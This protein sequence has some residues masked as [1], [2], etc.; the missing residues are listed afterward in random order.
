MKKQN[1]LSLL[2]L[3]ASIVGL[4]A[5]DQTGS[6]EPSNNMDAYKLIYNGTSTEKH[7]EIRDEDEF[8][9]SSYGYR[10][11]NVQ[12]YNGWNYSFYKDNIHTPLINSNGSKWESGENSLDNDGINSAEAGGYIAHSYTIKEGGKYAFGGTI[13][14]H[15]SDKGLLATVT[16]LRNGQQI[17]PKGNLISTTK[18]DE[19]GKYFETFQD[20]SAN[21]VITFLISGHN[22]YCNPVIRK[23][24]DLR[25]SLYTTHNDWGY[26]G[27]IHCFYHNDKLHLY[28]LWNT[29]WTDSGWFWNMQTT[30]DMFRY[31]NAGYDD[32]FLTNHYMAYGKV[33]DVVD[34]SIY[35]RARDC[36]TFYDEDVGKYRNIGLGYISN[37]PGNV[38]CDLFLRTSDDGTGLAWS[39]NAIPLKSFHNNGEPE[40]SQLIK[41]GNR[42]YLCTGI[43]GRSV[44][45]VG[46]MTYWFG[47]EGQTIDEI[48]WMNLE[49]HKI[50]GEDLCVPQIEKVRD[51]YYLFGWM[52]QNPTGSN[53]GGYKNLPREV[54]QREDG[55]LGTRIDIAADKLMNKGKLFDLTTANATSTNSTID[56]NSIYMLGNDRV[57]V[58][59]K[60][61]QTYVKFNVE[62]LNSTV[63]EYI[64]DDG[65]N[66][67][68]IAIEER[69]DGNT[70][71]KIHTKDYRVWSEVLLGKSNKKYE[72]KIVCHGSII[73]F[74][75]NDIMVLSGRTN[76]TLLTYTPGFE[77]NGE[78]KIDNISINRLAQLYDVYD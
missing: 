53:W 63:F 50:D 5:C 15:E 7:I 19:N 29:N 21:D 71:L 26:Y 25:D 57:D 77:A 39:S 20:F 2:L 76:S 35:T 47:E 6:S 69:E 44:H 31:K 64:M 45:G 13:I 59:G 1:F 65:I 61:E 4:S 18:N 42:W 33:A 73:E 40:C 72:C 14:Q 51:K 68:R 34:Y 10:F 23:G 11:N 28:H 17:Y 67:Y 49:P 48:D 38:R 70:Y 74:A 24:T 12:G 41:I 66:E 32:T 60:V 62:M 43:S 22:V 30:T 54:Y 8:N 56:T 58:V 46:T 27:D 16:V 52:P 37:L 36:T 55:T 75:V 78:T 3:T 9:R